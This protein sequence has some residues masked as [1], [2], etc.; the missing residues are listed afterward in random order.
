[1]ESPGFSKT[2]GYGAPFGTALGDEDAR[3]EP[4]NWAGRGFTVVPVDEP[5]ED[6]AG[7]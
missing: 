4:E 1:V 7:G 3:P 2:H 6:A 5:A